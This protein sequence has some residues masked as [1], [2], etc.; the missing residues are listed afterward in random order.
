MHAILRENGFELL[1]FREL[2][3]PDDAGEHPYYSTTPVGVG[4]TLARRG[5]LASA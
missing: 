3:A 1:D 4:E 5:D 2:F